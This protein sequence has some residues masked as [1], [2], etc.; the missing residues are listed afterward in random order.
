VIE[1]LTADI[2]K[3]TLISGVDLHREWAS[4]HWPIIRRVAH[5]QCWAIISQLNRVVT[6]DGHAFHRFNSIHE[7][8]DY[9]D[10]QGIPKF[11][12]DGT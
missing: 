9:L 2:D 7:A 5:L 6:S 11:G 10:Q 3:V 8:A 4:G 1:M 12:V